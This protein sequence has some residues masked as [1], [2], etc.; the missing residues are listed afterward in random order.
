MDRRTGW[1]SIQS[2]FI[3]TFSLLKAKLW[4]GAATL[5]CGQWFLLF[6][7][8]SHQNNIDLFL[9]T[10][11][12]QSSPTPCVT[13]FFLYLFISICP[14]SQQR[15][16]GITKKK[17]VKMSIDRKKEVKEF[18]IRLHRHTFKNRLLFAVDSNRTCS[19]CG[20]VKQTLS[21]G[22]SL[23]G[24]EAIWGLK[25]LMCDFSRG[26]ITATHSCFKLLH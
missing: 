13:F 25:Q 18:D 14:E 12:E 5:T 22:P 7:E 21:F 19:H 23:T 26:F 6:Y 9:V 11:R 4:P 10:K 20:K 3:F 16:A 2:S 1:I 24:E 15:F 8:L 17:T